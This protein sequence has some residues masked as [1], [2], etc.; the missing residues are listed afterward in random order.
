MAFESLERSD[1]EWR[2]AGKLNFLFE[3][4]RDAF[5]NVVGGASSSDDVNITSGVNIIRVGFVIVRLQLN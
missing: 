2:L 5:N 1:D 3:G 4:D